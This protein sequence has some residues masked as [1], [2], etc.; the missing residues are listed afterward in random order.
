MEEGFKECPYCGE[1]IRSTAKKCR[2]CDEWLDE[3]QAPAQQNYA[4]LQAPAQQQ[5]SAA[6]QA[7]P[8]QQN[9]AA[10][11]A[12]AQQQ[13]YAAP[14][15]PAQQQNFAAPQAPAPPVPPTSPI[16]VPGFTSYDYGQ[17]AKIDPMHV[18]EHR[19]YDTSILYLLIVAGMLGVLM[20]FIF[21]L[22]PESMADAFG[23]LS[24]LVNYLG[25][26]SVLQYGALGAFGM[27]TYMKTRDERWMGNVTTMSLVF[28]IAMFV[29]VLLTFIGMATFDP[30]DFYSSSEGEEYFALLP[31]ILGVVYG[32]IAMG[33]KLTRRIGW[34]LL[35]MFGVFIAMEF[36]DI[37]E[38]LN[39]RHSNKAIIKIIAFVYLGVPYVAFD[40][41]VKFLSGK[42]RE[43]ID[44]EEA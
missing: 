26:S 29:S 43:E 34:Y 40:S 37:S 44:D 9:Y 31:L 16:S 10:P 13:N 38:M 35:I 6:P 33:N 36:I 18:T 8:Q 2:Y 21:F 30:Y 3:T 11:Q 15:A 25:F 4:A 23:S 17:W 41:F 39:P 1:A 20:E 22:T 12:P 14:Q 42:R 5:N 19:L 27:M 32:C 24:G 7:Q 28:A